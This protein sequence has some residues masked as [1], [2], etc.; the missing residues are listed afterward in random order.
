M[1]PPRGWSPSV[2]PAQQV[3]PPPIGAKLDDQTL[4][5]PSPQ[6]SEPAAYPIQPPRGW[7]PAPY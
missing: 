5:P 2:N 6:G 7:P 1:P 3:I 4:M